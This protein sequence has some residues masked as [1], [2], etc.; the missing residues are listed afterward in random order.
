M[1]SLLHFQRLA[2]IKRLLA[3]GGPS[4]VSRFVIAI[5]VD[6]VNRKAL[7]WAMASMS[8]EPFKPTRTSPFLAHAYAASAVIL[9]TGMLVVCASL[10]DVLPA[11]VFGSVMHSVPGDNLPKETSATLPIASAKY[12]RINFN[13]YATVAHAL[14]DA[15]ARACFTP[16]KSNDHQ[17]PIAFTGYVNQPELVVLLCFR[18][19]AVAFMTF[20]QSHLHC[21]SA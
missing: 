14:K 13:Y 1:L 10:N 5:V 19:V 20:P 15:P 3:T 9:V 16:Q 18:L 6:A 4:Y 2:F 21:H 12:V 17:S 7:V 11:Q 8:K